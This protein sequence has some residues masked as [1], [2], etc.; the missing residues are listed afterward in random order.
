MIYP[1]AWRAPADMAKTL[2]EQND[3]AQA[4]LIYWQRLRGARVEYANE[5]GSD[6][7]TQIYLGANDGF[8]QWMQDKYGIQLEFIDGNISGAY[9]VLD[10]KKL[11]MFLLKYPG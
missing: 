1:E 6:S 2:K 7:I 10:E 11:M 3:R 9:T 5:T 8:Y 4:R